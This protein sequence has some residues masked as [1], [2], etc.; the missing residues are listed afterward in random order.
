MYLLFNLTNLSFDE[1]KHV[2]TSFLTLSQ[3]KMTPF[4]L[5]N[6]FTQASTQIDVFNEARDLI[7]SVIDGYNVCIF[8]Y[9]QVGAEVYCFI[10]LTSQRLDQEKHSPWMVLWISLVS[11]VA[12]LPSSLWFDIISPSQDRFSL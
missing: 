4:E 1:I 9:G 2:I 7:V 6:V 5:D 11:T 3:G 12:L 8:A 10:M